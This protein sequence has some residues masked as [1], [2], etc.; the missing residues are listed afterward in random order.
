MKTC[1]NMARKA[2]REAAARRAAGESDP[3]G[4]AGFD[5]FAGYGYTADRRESVSALTALRAGLAARKARRE[6][7]AA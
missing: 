4:S 2:Y 1:E 7:A 3:R 5:Y 6:A